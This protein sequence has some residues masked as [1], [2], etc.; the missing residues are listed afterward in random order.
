MPSIQLDHVSMTFKIRQQYQITF[1]EYLLRR[2]S[3]QERNPVTTI[4]ALRDVN[5]NIAT[6]E[7]VAVIG[8][9][10]SGKSTLL[11]L[12]AGVYHPTRGKRRVRGRVSSLFELNLG[13]EMES[14]GWK[15]MLYRGYLQGETPRTMRKKT[16]AIAAFS[17]LGRFLDLP[18]RYYSAGMMV[19]LAFSIATAIQPEI[20]LVDEVLSAGDLAFQE[21]ARKR[22]CDIMETAGIV[23]MVSHDLESL[24]GFC[25]RGVWL[26]KGQVAKDG[27]IDEV[28]DAYVGHVRGHAGSIDT[29]R[30]NAEAALA[31]TAA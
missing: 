29:G 5:L 18:V 9:N 16:E 21:R 3:R 19:R 6:S 15:N 2:M 1:K 8:A 23:V 28:I 12:L 26:E 7:R 17:G 10:G 22:M 4:H 11:R 25:E 30:P 14:T 24:R 20:L 13:F 27:P 31:G